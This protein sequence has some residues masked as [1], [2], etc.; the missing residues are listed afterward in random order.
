ME[1]KRFNVGKPWRSFFKNKL[2]VQLI[3]H[4]A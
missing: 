3:E 2:I 1:A 4:D